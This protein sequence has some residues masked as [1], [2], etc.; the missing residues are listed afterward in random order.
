[1]RIYLTGAS[2]F[3]GSLADARATARSLGVER[4]R[5]DVMLARLRA[6]VASSWCLA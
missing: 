3:V 2:G 6:E 5:L 1:M 4:P